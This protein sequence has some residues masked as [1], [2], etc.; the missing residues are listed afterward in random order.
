MSTIPE[1]QL[2]KITLKELHPIIKKYYS[3]LSTKPDGNFLFNMISNWFIGN[4]TL[5]K[6]YRALTVFTIV[7]YKKEYLQFIETETPFDTNQDI[8]HWTM[9]KYNS[10]LNVIKTNKC[11]CNE[12]HLFIVIFLCSLFYPPSFKYLPFLFTL[13]K[14]KSQK[15][16]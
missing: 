1:N 14:K 2:D 6:I 13:F 7:K 10:I 12:Y 9:N 15:E 3:P 11:W 8:L 4:E 5:T 16:I